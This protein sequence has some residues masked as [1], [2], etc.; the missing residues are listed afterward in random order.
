MLKWKRAKSILKSWG[1]PQEL[2]PVKLIGFEMED[3]M[4]ISSLQV[5]TVKG[6]CVISKEA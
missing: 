4:S 5:N 3:L 6:M 1:F 2:T